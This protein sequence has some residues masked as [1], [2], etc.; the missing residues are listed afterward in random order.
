MRP[1][2][3]G[4][5]VL[6]LPAL[7]VF[8]SG[9]LGGLAPAAATCL[10]AVGLILLDGTLGTQR[11]LT[12]VRTV[13]SRLSI[14]ASARVRVAVRSQSRGRFTVVVRDGVP[15]TLH[16][17]T[18]SGTVAVT[19]GQPDGAFEYRIRPDRRG[20]YLFDDAWIEVPGRLGLVRRPRRVM[21]VTRV[22]VVPDIRALRRY[23]LLARRAMTAEAGFR[24]VRR[25]GEGTE[26]ERLRE[27]LPGDPFRRIDWKATARRQRPITR[28]MEAERRRHVM[29]LVDAGRWM[30]QPTDRLLKLDHALNAVLLAAHVADRC[31]DLT[32]VMTFADHVLSFLAPS[33]GRDHQARMLEELHTTPAALVEPAFTTAFRE[34][35]QRLKKR[36][37]VVLISDFSDPTTAN[38]LLATLP[39]LSRRHLLLCIHLLDPA[40][41]AL[42]TLSPKTLRDANR[43]ALA[44]K[45]SIERR[46]TLDRLRAQGTHVATCRADALTATVVN[47][48]L[49]IKGRGEL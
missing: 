42:G 40:L 43:R 21:C 6:V 49:A 5:L 23:D 37:L 47:R 22:S 32:G 27:Y 25:I 29:F 28:E 48:Y 44:E 7:P 20:S 10:L 19:S 14:G 39:V 30:S 9:G 45:L 15:P 34:V 16:P 36:T 4:M 18:P 13:S 2:R 1:T 12:A 24:T 17:D 3:I 8:L 26:V 38:A 11:D 31:G 46:R 35:A 33:S 41:E